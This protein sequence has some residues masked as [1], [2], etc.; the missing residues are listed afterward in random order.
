LEVTPHR[1]GELRVRVPDY[2]AV[3]QATVDGMPARP[4]RD[5]SYLAFGEVR[6]GAQV[7]LTFPMPEK[8]TE[9]RTW[10]TPGRRCNLPEKADPVVKERIGVEWRGNTVLAID[11][12]ET[13]RQPLHR[14]Y[15]ERKERYQQGHG[16]DARA[17]FFLPEREYHW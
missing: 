6:D 5:G 12:D 10:D 7:A 3:V 11:Y 15:L 14:L 9:E 13:S 2:A 1:F 17:A 16:R 4:S 8:T